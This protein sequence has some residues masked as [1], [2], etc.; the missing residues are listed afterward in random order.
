LPGGYLLAAKAIGPGLNVEGWAAKAFG[1]GGPLPMMTMI[2][3]K[4]EAGQTVRRPK[5][6]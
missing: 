3:E 5:T 6:K 1:Q 4:I 2:D